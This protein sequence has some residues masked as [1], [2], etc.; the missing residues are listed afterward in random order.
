VL[1]YGEGYMYQPQF[2]HPVTNEYLPSELR[3]ETIL[4]EVGDLTGKTWDD[5][6]LKQWEEM[7][8]GGQVW[9][10]RSLTPNCEVVE[11]SQLH[12]DT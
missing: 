11:P 12:H 3:G 9:A 10:G 2:S 8:N 7:E 1:G 6:A 4:R 5:D